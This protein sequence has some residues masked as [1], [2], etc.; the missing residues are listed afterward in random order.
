[1][2]ASELPGN[3]WGNLADGLLMMSAKRLLGVMC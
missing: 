2:Q 3:I 1:V